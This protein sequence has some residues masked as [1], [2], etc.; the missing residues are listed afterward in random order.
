MAYNLTGAEL[1]KRRQ[2]C[3]LSRKQLADK[4]HISAR[5][6]EGWEQGRYRISP[7]VQGYILA[8]LNAIRALPLSSQGKKEKSY[9]AYEEEE[10][11]ERHRCREEEE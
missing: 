1:K 3:G 4:L 5:T 7:I 6:L 9:L 10:R 11:E 8:S 2:G